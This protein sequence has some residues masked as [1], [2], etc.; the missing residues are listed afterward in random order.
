M[1]RKF[2]CFVFFVALV[3]C[4]PRP[5]VA[6]DI[7]YSGVCESYPDQCRGATSLGA[8]AGAVRPASAEVVRFMPWPP[9]VPSSMVD[10]TPRIPLK[11]RLFDVA[12]R[13]ESRLISR[14]YDQ[15]LYYG[16]PGGFALVTPLE[17]FDESGHPSQP[18]R[19]TEG[20]I[21]GWQGAWPYV[22]SLLWGGEGRFR[23]FVFAVSNERFTPEPA[24]PVETDVRRWESEGT[25]TLPSSLGGKTVPKGTHVTLLVY[26]FTA[27]R[28][29]TGGIEQAHDRV[30]SARHLAWLGLGP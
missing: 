13:L 16:I 22:E 4:Q 24:P 28:G 3:A 5:H 7:D 15:P 25:L 12:T 29:R 2:C 10:V 1:L 23:L 21:G 17:R 6:A 11:G 8:L 18:G 20:K 27:N 30:P 14:G 9:P 26:E 19:F